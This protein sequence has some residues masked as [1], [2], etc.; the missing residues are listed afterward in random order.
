M[1]D[2]KGKRLLI[3]EEALTDYKGH[4]YSWIK[5]IREIHI[6]EGVEVLIAGSKSI[7]PAIKEEFNVYPAYTHNNWSGIY[8]YQQSWRRYASVFL[9]NYRIYSQTRKLLRVTGPVDCIL[10]PAVRVHH[11]MA[12][13]KLCKER[14]GKDF[15]RVILFLLTSEAIYNEDFSEFNFKTSSKLIQNILRRFANDVKAGRVILAGDSHITCQEYEKLSGVPFRVFSSPSAGLQATLE[16]KNPI[17]KKS[18]MTPTF[19]ILGVSVIDKG[20]DVLQDAILQLLEETPALNARFIIQWSTPT[21]DYDGNPVPISDKLRNAKQVQ[22]LEQVLD[23]ESYKSYLQQA[24]FVVLPYRR[25]VYFNRLSGVAIEAACAGLPM[26]VTENTWLAW[27]LNAFGAG[28]T[29]KDGDSNDLAQKLK[30]CI[31]HSSALGKKAQDRKQTAL[32]MNSTEIYLQK[33][34]Q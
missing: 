5:A 14:L 31:D 22:L 26:I 20:I 18:E 13:R 27:A 25:K 28:V 3:C 21:I 2:L 6:K 16:T 33:V 8:D 9:H 15:K 23:E 24:N 29:I 19:V 17:N 11:L 12:W 10:L 34:W 7:D 32:E 4:F 30:Y 1:N